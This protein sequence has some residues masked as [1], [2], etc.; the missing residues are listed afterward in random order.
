MRILVTGATGGVGGSVVNQ[1]SDTGVTVR[2]ASR[3]RKD[4]RTQGVEDVAADLA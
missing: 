1:L 2:A 4:H 3:N